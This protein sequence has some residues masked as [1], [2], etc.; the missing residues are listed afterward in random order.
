LGYVYRK[1]GSRVEFGW[2]EVLSAR[3]SEELVRK[4]AAFD[5][6]FRGPME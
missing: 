1:D 4:D 6:Y 3:R 5:Y 2:D